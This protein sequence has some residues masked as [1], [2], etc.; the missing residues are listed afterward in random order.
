M[1][2]AGIPYSNLSVEEKLWAYYLHACIKQVQG[3]AVDKQFA[4]N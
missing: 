4:K 2:N 1:A 3:G